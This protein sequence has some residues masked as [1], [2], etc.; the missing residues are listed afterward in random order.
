MGWMQKLY[1]TYETI[2]KNSSIIADNDLPVPV[3]HSTQQAHIEI[4]VNEQGDFLR[5]MTIGNED[6]LIPVTE[7][8]AART[9]GG[10]PHPLCDKIQYVAGDYTQH[11]GKKESFFDD[12]GKGKSKT[13][14]YLSVISSWAETCS[15][16]HL[17]AI[18]T[19]V[20][21]RSVVAD[22]LKTRTLYVDNEGR[23]ITSWTEN[24]DPPMLFAKSLMKKKDKESGENIQDQ[25]DAFVRWRVEVLG[26]PQSAVWE[27]RSLQ[28]AW[29]DHNANLLT[30][31]GLCYASGQV[32]TALAKSH[33][34]KVRHSGDKARIISSNDMANFTFRGRFVTDAEA[35]GISYEVSQKAHSALRWLIKRQAY[36]NGS[37]IIVAWAISGHEIP[38]LMA[39][40]FYLLEDSAFA[41]LEK[42]ATSLENFTNTGDIGQLYSKR[43]SKKIAGY[44]AKLPSTENIVIMGLD[45]ATTGRLSIT[46]YREVAGAELLDRIESWHLRYAWY[47]HYS[48]DMQF[49]GSP[50]P[51]DIAESAFGRRLDDKIRRST[52]ERLLPC[53]IDERTFPSGIFALML[54]RVINRQGMEDWEWEK[55]LG[56]AC[57]IY[58]GLHKERG[59]PMAL[60]EERYT[61]DY[62]YGR[63][64][65]IAEHTES[66]ALYVA[67]E[68][69]E[70]NAARLMHRFST[71]PY[72]TWLN[73][74]KSLTPYKT[75]L[76]SKRASFLNIMEGLL[77]DVHSRFVP[78][79]YID[80]SHLNGEFL[81][82]YHCQR[83]ALRF[84]KQE[85]E[86]VQDENDSNNIAG[87]KEEDV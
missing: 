2:E 28:S 35:C 73:I 83:R 84:G 86:D 46:Y 65:A 29:I 16:P 59:Y 43:L 66:K 32:E 70:T 55:T 24:E 51:Q 21:K 42:K 87:S 77:D 4:V 18:L 26:D 3:A 15:H 58:R 31:K 6:T 34:N 75:R 27:N 14:G 11:G 62:L 69:R 1:E 38:D 64:L 41:E 48:K 85:N 45:S 79:D 63:L 57:G 56:I 36:R 7:S 10:A 19:Y 81:L 30:A 13:A 68:K 33:P 71:H 61:R 80:D 47:Q 60:D 37:Q 20:K 49:I 67:G 52:V 9:S 74:E 40:T 22:L 12:F 25:G 8:S 76:K 23:L 82:G 44:R 72:S 5:A 50:S 78:E 39:N 53:I 17:H 54:N